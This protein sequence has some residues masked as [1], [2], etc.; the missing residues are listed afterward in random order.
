MIEI[1]HYCRV[2]PAIGMDH[3]LP[4]TRGGTDEP[5]NLVP[6]CGHCNSSKGNSTPEEWFS[7]LILDNELLRKK[8]NQIAKI[9]QESLPDGRQKLATEGTSK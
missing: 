5:D 6:A 7:R 4:R 3:V 1:C 9:C 2:R 8:T